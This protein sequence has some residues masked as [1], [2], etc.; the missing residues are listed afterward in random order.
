MRITWHGQ[1]CVLIETGEGK[2]LLVDPFINGNPLSDLDADTVECDVII[3]T[4]GHNDHIGD[5][6]AI[7]RRTGA[8]IISTAEI[9]G[10][11]KQKGLRAHGMQ[12]GGGHLFPFGYLKQTR[13]IHGSAYTER[14][15]TVVPLGLATGFL[16]HHQG[17]TVYHAGDTALFSDMRLIGG[18]FPIDLALLP[19]GDNYTMG[20]QDAARA[21]AF[22]QAKQVVPVH[23]NTFPLIEQD[24]HDFIRRLPE[25]VG[26]VLNP[27][28]GISL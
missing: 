25:G 17:K 18:D 2:R 28:E 5:T 26:I 1:S 13:A 4:H 11:F 9:A 20:P 12:P 15:G 16:F 10:Y 14:D 8:V 24:P 19:I 23:Y 3:V 7:A 27:G 22:L 21:A 6:E